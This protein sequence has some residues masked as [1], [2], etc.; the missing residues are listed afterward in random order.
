VLDLFTLDHYF[1]ADGKL[2][3]TQ[4]EKRHAGIYQCFATNELGSVYG[5]LMLQVLPKQV[6]A[7]PTSDLPESEDTELEGMLY[8]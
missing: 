8:C 4:V 3:I 5:S 2:N 1:F 7:L 6:T